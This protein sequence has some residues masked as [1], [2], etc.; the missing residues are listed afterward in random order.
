MNLSLRSYFLGEVVF[1]I[2]IVFGREGEGVD[3][4]GFR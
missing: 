1:H 2:C 3:E 4:A